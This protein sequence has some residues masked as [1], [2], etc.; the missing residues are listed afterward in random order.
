MRVSAIPLL[1]LFALL[2]HGCQQQAVTPA[3]EAAVFAA[4]REHL[5]AMERE[6]ID[7]AMGTIHSQSPGFDATHDLAR[8]LFAQA[9]LKYSVADLKVIRRTRDAIH[10]SFLQQTRGSDGR[11]TRMS[12]VHVLREEEGR[13]KIYDTPQSQVRPLPSSAT[14]L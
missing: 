13:W 2:L 7:A 6:D 5:A 10:V 1:A 8:Q 3:E 14:P 11:E 4:I 12:G 9:D